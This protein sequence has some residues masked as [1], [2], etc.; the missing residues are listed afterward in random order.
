MYDEETEELTETYA[1]LSGEIADLTKTASTPGGISLF[2]DE[3]KN[4]YKS[5]YEI[6]KEIASIWDELEDKNQAQLLEKLFGKTRAQAGAAILS[7][8]SQA[9]EALKTME[10]SAGSADREMAII[11]ESIDYKLN[12]L[13]QTWVG[14]SQSLLERE[15]IGNAVDALTALS[16]A[17]QFV[18]DKL[19]LLGTLGLGGGIF[20]A[21]KTKGNGRPKRRVS[22]MNMPLVA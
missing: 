10:E 7:N 9:E 15:D 3:T 20:A 16:E 14:F 18:I 11:E 12:R 5:T 6:L 13:S 8:F 1:N 22:E 21:F 19:G 17:I 4:T 2:T